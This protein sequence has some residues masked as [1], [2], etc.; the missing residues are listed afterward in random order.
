[1][2]Q[3]NVPVICSE[4]NNSHVRQVE[5]IA[6]ESFAS[7][8]EPTMLSSFWCPRCQ[9]PQVVKFLFE[10]NPE[11]GDVDIKVVEH[12]QV[13]AKYVQSPGSQGLTVKPKASKRI[14]STIE[15]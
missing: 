2:S 1:M 12:V 11:N 7:G 10:R 9:I 14:H 8:R 3:K 4:C 13:T 5:V 6:P 15:E